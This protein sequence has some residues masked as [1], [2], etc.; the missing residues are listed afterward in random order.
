MSTNEMLHHIHRHTINRLEQLITSA[1]NPGAFLVGYKYEKGENL[2]SVNA[3]A[4]FVI[5]P[6]K[7]PCGLKL[8]LGHTL[9]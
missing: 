4:K 7:I 2:S 3:M 6:K 1:W 8:G 9:V 5:V